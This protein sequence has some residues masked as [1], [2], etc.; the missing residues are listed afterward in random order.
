MIYLAQPY[1]HPDKRIKVARFVEMMKFMAYLVK[2]GGKTPFPIF[3][4][5]VHWHHVAHKHDFPKDFSFWQHFNEHM[6]RRATGIYVLQLDGWKESKGL[7]HELVY[8]KGLCLP[9]VAVHKVNLEYVFTQ[10]SNIQTLIEEMT[11]GK[12]NKE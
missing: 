12:D 2:S 11:V 7:H 6:L 8:S 5:I 4:P 1:N 10:V 3:S 9:C